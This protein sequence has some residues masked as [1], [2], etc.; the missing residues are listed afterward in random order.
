[1]RRFGRCCFSTGRTSRSLPDP[2]EPRLGD[3][4]Q[5]CVIALWGLFLRDHNK[6]IFDNKRAASRLG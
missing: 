3:R 2:A 5:R 6:R 4:V 1:M